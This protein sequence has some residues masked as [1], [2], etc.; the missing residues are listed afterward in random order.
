MHKGM[1]ILI[2][3][4]YKNHIEIGNYYLTMA[5]YNK[6]LGDLQAEYTSLICAY[7]MYKQDKEK[8]K[9]ILD[10]LHKIVDNLL[11]QEDYD[12]ALK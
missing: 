11:S 9:E 6:L 12:S 8:E 2:D 5:Q 7:S 1:N 3:S 4:R 10:I